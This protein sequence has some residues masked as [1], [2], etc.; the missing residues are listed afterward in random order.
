MSEHQASYDDLGEQL[1]QYGTAKLIEEYLTREAPTEGLLRAVLAAE[2][3]T[4]VE[5]P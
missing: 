3:L 1:R 5:G 2:T 4:Q